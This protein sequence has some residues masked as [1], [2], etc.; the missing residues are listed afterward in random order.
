MMLTYG[1]APFAAPPKANFSGYG[2]GRDVDRAHP[3]NPVFGGGETLAEGARGLA[4]RGGAVAARPRLVDPVEL[5]HG[6][7]PDRLGA[8]A[9]CL[10]DRHGLRA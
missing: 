7:Q 9:R 10:D 8:A 1:F 5:G 4:D 2:G 3:V 6:P